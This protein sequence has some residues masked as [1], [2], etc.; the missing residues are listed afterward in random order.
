MERWLFTF[1]LDVRFD[2]FS[3]NSRKH[4]LNKFCELHLESFT[5]RSRE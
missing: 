1:E 3:C 2:Y 4:A 5:A